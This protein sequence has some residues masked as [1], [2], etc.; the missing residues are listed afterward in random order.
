[1]YQIGVVDLCGVRCLLALDGK[2]I[3]TCSS[4]SFSFNCFHSR[5]YVSILPE[6]LVSFAGALPGN[7][8]RNSA[9]QRV[10]HGR[11]YLRILS[12]FP[13]GCRQHLQGG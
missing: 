3:W 1:M 10:V 7:D 4:C 6:R 5:T 2:N 13:H 11:I 12:Q 8:S 9:L